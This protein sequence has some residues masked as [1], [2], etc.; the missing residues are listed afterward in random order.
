MVT[1]GGMLQRVRVAD[2]SVVG[3]NTQGVR[4]IRLDKGKED[5]LVSLARIP[6]EIVEDEA[7]VDVPVTPVAESSA[8]EVPP[9]VE[10][11]G[12]NPP[13]AE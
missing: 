1:S 13:L 8:S 5:A 12:T 3:R 6:A 7:V 2:I 10:A 9:A 4:I 11:D